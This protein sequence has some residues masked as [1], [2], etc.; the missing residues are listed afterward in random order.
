MRSLLSL[1]LLPAL[2]ICT[3]LTA[4]AATDT[5]PMPEDLPGEYTVEGWDPGSV[6]GGPPNYKGTVTLE[7]WGDAYTYRGTFDEQSYTGA[8]LYDPLTGT[9]S[10]SFV[11]VDGTEQGITMLKYRSGIFSGVWLMDGTADGSLGTEIWTR[12]K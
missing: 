6:C 12:K 1:V 4:Q 2:I 3:V 7:A 5:Q 10:L 11:N 8:A 9:I